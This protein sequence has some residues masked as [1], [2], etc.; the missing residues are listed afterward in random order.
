MAKNAN[1]PWE[2]L[3]YF[4]LSCGSV[5]DSYLFSVAILS[6]LKKLCSFDEGLI[7]FVD[8]N[9]KIYNQYLLGVDEKWSN[10][11]LEYYSTVGS[12]H[13]KS[14]GEVRETPGQPFISIKT[15][16]KEP[17]SEFISDFIRPRGLKCSLGFVLFDIN[18]LPRTIFALDKKREDRFSEDE[19]AVLSKA[20]PQLNN[21][22]KNFY[23]RPTDRLG[24]GQN[25]WGNTSLT[26]RELE[27]ASLLCQGVSP[28]NIS[29][30]LHIARYT[31]YKHIANIYKK[32][33]VSSRQEL[34][35]RLLN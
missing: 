27:V 16:Y 5:H 2:K 18:G 4:I 3:Y 34:L 28:A 20:I 22:H 17:H 30:A 12:K 10:L 13:C 9:G 33:Q 15:W 7:Y 25:L 11:Y 21:L 31:V 26:A 35:A 32:M 24:S 19:L 14:L 29:K 23:S 8:G 6:G 1:I